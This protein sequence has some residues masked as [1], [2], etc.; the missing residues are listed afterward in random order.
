MGEKG[1]NHRDGGG[2]IERPIE[3]HG[4]TIETAWGG[5]ERPIRGT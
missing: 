4:A 1:N 5:I 2:G 3:L